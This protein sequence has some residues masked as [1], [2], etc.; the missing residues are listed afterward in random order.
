MTDPF[1]RPIAAGPGVAESHIS[2][3]FFSADRA[4]KLLKPIRTSFLDFSTVEKRLQAVDN[5]VSLNRRM[6]PDV[7]LG[8][9]DVEERGELVDRMIV[10]RRLPDDRRLTRLVT[11]PD[12]DDLLRLIVR[13]VAAFHA[14]EPPVLD[15]VEI[16]G[17]DAVAANWEDNVADMEPLIGEVFGDA[18]FART[19]ELARRYLDFSD[20]LFS[21]RLAKGFVRDGHGDLTAEDIFCLDDGPRILDCLAFDQRLRIADVLCDVAF[22]AMDMDRLAGPTA[23]EAVWRYYAEFSNEHHPASLAHH[24]VAYRAH[25]RAKVA[26]IRHRQGD[27]K[28][29]PQARSYLDLCLRHLEMARRRLVIVGGSP[30]TGKTT[31]SRTISERVGWSMVGSDSIRKELTGHGQTD[32]EFVEPGQGIYSDDITVRTYDELLRRATLLL[33]RGESVILDASFNT[34]THRRAARAVAR[35]CG[36]DVVELECVLDSTTAKQ[37]IQRR[38]ERGD[39]PSD[40]RPAILDELRSQQE[41][42]PEATPIRTA[43]PL[44]EAALVAL[45]ALRRH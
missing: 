42:W 41:P 30:G 37:R 35:D 43:A 16:A 44:E 29:A 38:L 34:S 3:V 39:D 27:P 8:T 28:A 45:G 11:S 18:E 36:A 20:G 17:R 25:V 15:A 26:S 22:L 9:A 6:A 4:Y 32:R 33:E 10:M 13:A 12:L 1:R 24:Y 40:A 31:I 19:S 2:T 7:Y 14:A 5:E 23:T 21:D